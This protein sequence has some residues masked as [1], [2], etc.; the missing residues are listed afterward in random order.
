LREKSLLCTCH[1][2]FDFIHCSR[3]F[4]VGDW[5]VLVQWVYA[6]GE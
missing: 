2:H 1:L 3:P 5:V 4:P 6:T